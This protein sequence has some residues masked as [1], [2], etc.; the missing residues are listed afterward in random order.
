MASPTIVAIGDSITLGVGDGV[1]DARGDVGWAAHTAR[2]LGAATFIN[3]AANGT[4]VR[5]LCGAQVPA[6]LAA[7][8]DIV[9][10]TA[11]GNDVLRGDFDSLQVELDLREALERLVQPGRTILTVTI[12]RIGLFDL[13]PSSIA[14]VMAR[15]VSAL[16]GAIRGA[17]IATGAIAVDGAA[18]FRHAGGVAWHIDRIHPSAAGHRAIAAAA[19]ERLAPHWPA[20]RHIDPAPAPPRVAERAW[21]LVR[22]GAPWAAKRSRDLIP[23]VAQAVTREMLEERR[24]RVRGA[25]RA[26]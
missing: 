26:G 2:A 12:D 19:L 8:P 6:A 22:N 14:A 9:L 10:V 23:Q 25:A 13:L 17:A 11:G 24:S 16:N 4:R 5:D 15:R 20:I 18:V 1:Q 3:L 21:W 7:R